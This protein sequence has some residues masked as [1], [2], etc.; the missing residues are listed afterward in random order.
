M[1]D[2]K[3]FKNEYQKLNKTLLL[4]RHGQIPF[5]K[6]MEIYGKQY[7]TIEEFENKLTDIVR[8]YEA[9]LCMFYN[10]NRTV[11][12][13][14]FKRFYSKFI[15]ATENEKILY[16]SVNGTSYDELLKKLNKIKGK[17]EAEKESEAGK[18]RKELDKLKKD[19]ESMQKLK[20]ELIALGIAEDDGRFNTISIKP[21]RFV[22]YLEYIESHPS[23]K[24]I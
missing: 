13:R 4:V 23:L 20:H 5:E 15:D 18:I 19:I 2:I 12:K 11:N 8:Q 22:D 14:A 17:L 7:K 3:T 10:I 24:K 1:V 9:S 16:E 21:E 6:I